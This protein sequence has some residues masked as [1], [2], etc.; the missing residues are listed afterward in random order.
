[1]N[2]RKLYHTIESIASQTFESDEALLKHVLEEVIRNEQVNVKGGRI[3]KLNPNKRSYTLLY[4]TGGVDH[5]PEGFTIRVSE[6]PIFLEVGR[7]KSALADETNQ[8]LRKKGIR[9]YSAT[10]VG[11]K[12]RVQNYTLYPYVLALNSDSMD[13]RFLYTLNIVSSAVTSAI[14]SRKIERKAQELERDLD[15]AREIQ[16]SILPAHEYRFAQYELFGTSLSD[17]IVGG[18]FFDYLQVE[19]NSDRLGVAIGDAASKG[20]SAAVEA[21][22]VS[23]ALKMGVDY[24]TKASLLIQKINNLVN[25]TFPDDRFVTLFYAEL[26]NTKNGL[27]IYVNA[28]HNNPMLFKSETNSVEL[29]DVTGPALGLSPDQKYSVENV[30]MKLGDILLCYTDGITEAPNANFELYGEERLAQKLVEVKDLSAKEITE[31]ILEDVQIFSAQAP[32]GDDKTIV[33][34]KRIK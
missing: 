29:L 22:Y 34:I 24:Q 19:E 7:R 6:Y 27:C 28:G 18:D 33:T 17:R 11:E 15:K 3:W 1:M 23:G 25:R 2:Q 21:L 26:L 5:I 13:E 10:G 30:N 14:K 32:Y 16:R 4:Q 20:L 9:T 8:Y 31:L 12:I